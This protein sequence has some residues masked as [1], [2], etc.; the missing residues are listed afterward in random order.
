MDHLLKA[1]KEFKKFKETRDSIKYYCYSIVK[2]IVK[3]SGYDKYI[4]T[5]EFNKLMSDN[6]AARLKKAKLANKND[7]ANF[8]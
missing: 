8:V 7:I 5:Q 4:S 2:S 6:V 1:K 3:I